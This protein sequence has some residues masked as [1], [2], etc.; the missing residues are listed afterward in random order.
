MQSPLQFHQPFLH[1]VRR[2]YLVLFAKILVIMKLSTILALSIL[3]LVSEANTARWSSQARLVDLGYAKHIP[4]TT[5][6]TTSGRNISLYKNIRFAKPPTGDLRFRL[7]DPNVSKIPDIQDGK[8]ADEQSTHCISS[9]PAVAPFPPY[10]GTTWGREDCLFLDVWVPDGIEPGDKVP[11]LH[12][13]VGTAYAFGSKEMFVSPKGL[14]DMMSDD[15]KFIFVANNY[16][17]GVSGWTYLPGADLVANLG[18]HDCLAAAQWTA[19]YVDRFGGDP[20]RITVLGQSAGAGII[21]LLTVLNGGKGKLPFQQV[22]HV[23]CS[24]NNRLLIPLDRPSYHP[25]AS[26]RDEVPFN[27]RR[28]PLRLFWMKQT[29]LRPHAS[30]MSLKQPSFV[31][32]RSLSTA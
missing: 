7:P 16:R 5:Y 4:T 19:K 6:T 29:A 14:F 8:V 1:G 3:G 12:W 9:M 20:D 10:N 17:L 13:F 18:M 27:I 26:L 2:S 25:P 21:G 28:V 15:T 22:R 30:A 32:T 24:P 23:R 11:V 31:S